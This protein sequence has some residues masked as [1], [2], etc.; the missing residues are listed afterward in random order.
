MVLP[1]LIE[2][3]AKAL[4]LIVARA[5]LFRVVGIVPPTVNELAAIVVS[6]VPIEKEL[7]PALIS[8]APSLTDWPTLPES[9]TLPVPFA[10]R[11][12]G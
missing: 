7:L 4:V 8:K 1:K 10:V 5:V 11:V 12:S 6:P 3:P 9:V 2:P